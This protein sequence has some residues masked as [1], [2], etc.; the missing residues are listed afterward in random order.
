MWPERNDGVPGPEWRARA[1][2]APAAREPGPSG[3]VSGNPLPGHGYYVLHADYPDLAGAI[4]IPG[5]QPG[6]LAPY[7]ER[8]QVYPVEFHLHIDPA[9]DRGRLF[10]LLMAAGMNKD[11][12]TNAALGATLAKL[13][14]GIPD[15]YK[16]H[17][18]AYKKLL[19]SA[20]SIETP[21]KDL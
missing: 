4:A 16:E 3:L 10:P 11:A 19:A 2:A 9:R 18:D 1:D 17:A 14:A 7:Q 15:L 21:D 20:T 13:D 5:A 12:A 8:P 6:I